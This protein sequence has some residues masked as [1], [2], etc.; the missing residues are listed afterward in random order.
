MPVRTF[1]IFGHLK[2]D[3]FKHIK[4]NQII[5]YGHMLLIFLRVFNHLC[6][7]N[8]LIAQHLISHVIRKN[9]INA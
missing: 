6:T 8:Q 1:N 2:V 9:K 4:S 5:F 7:T 3:F